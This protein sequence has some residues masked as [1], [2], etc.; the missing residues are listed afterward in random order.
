[1]DKQW[2][3]WANYVLESLDDIKKEQECQKKL[4]NNLR[5]EVATDRAINNTRTGLIAGF[6]S[7]A[8]MAIGIFISW[9]TLR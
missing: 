5:I 1:M 3:E 7:F 2:S 6:V 8:V 4:I 9:L